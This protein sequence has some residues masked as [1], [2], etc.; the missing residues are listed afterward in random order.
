MSIKEFLE[1]E[2]SFSEVLNFIESESKRI[3]A[4]I[5]AKEEAKKVSK[6]S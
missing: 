2:P 5:K 6:I 4:E 3:A 1:T